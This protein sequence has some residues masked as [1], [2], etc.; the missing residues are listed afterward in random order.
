M[1]FT[2]ICIHI[3][4]EKLLKKKQKKKAFIML[5]SCENI[6]NERSILQNREYCLSVYWIL[7]QCTVNFKGL[8]VNVPQSVAE[9]QTLV[10]TLKMGG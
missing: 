5:E 7:I 10:N 4:I 3:I 6:N 2:E 8:I 9:Y 1:D